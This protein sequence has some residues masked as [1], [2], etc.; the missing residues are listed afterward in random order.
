MKKILYCL[1]FYIDNSNSPLQN[2]ISKNYLF[3]L[4]I[5]FSLTIKTK[6][7]SMIIFILSFS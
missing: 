6:N 7:T 5:F 2:T 3:I 4:V 1:E